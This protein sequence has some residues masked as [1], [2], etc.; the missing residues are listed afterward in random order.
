VVASLDE[1]AVDLLL[2]GRLAVHR[3]PP[4]GR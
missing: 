1:V 3:P 4:T 2:E